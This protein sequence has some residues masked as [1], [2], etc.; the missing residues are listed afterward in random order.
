MMQRDDWE[1]INLE[2]AK[3]E[4]TIKFALEINQ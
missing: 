3:K 1:I 4:Y 2:E